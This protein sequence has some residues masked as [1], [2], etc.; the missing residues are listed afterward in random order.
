MRRV[1]PILPILLLAAPVSAE[2]LKELVDI[3][4]ARPNALIGMGLV[5]GLNG[6]GDDASS[7]A[8]RRQ[9]AGMMQKLG[10]NLDATALKQLK[11]KNI[12]QVSV[13]ASLPPFAHP[14]TGLDVVVSSVGTA[15]SLGGGTLI[16]TPLKGPDLVTYALA[17]GPVSLGGFSI[18]GQS[19]SKV[20]KN[21]PTVARIPNGARIE[22][23]PP[24]QIDN[25]GVVALS[26]HMPDFTTASRIAKAINETIGPATATVNDPGTVTLD[27]S[28]RKA[29]LVELMAQIEM[30]EV[31]PDIV[32]RVVIDERTGTVVVG[33]GV[34]L[35]AATIAH[36]GL[37][38][39]VQE[40]KQTSQPGPLTGKGATTVTVPQSNVEVEE[41]DGKLVYL[42]GAATAADV[43]NAMN[44][45][46]AKPR[47]LVAIFQALAQAGAIRAE[48][49]V[50]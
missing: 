41:A 5:V 43:A 42:S 28:G 18:E 7:P 37:T 49:V 34:R 13:T 1:L 12:A 47:D 9:L 11:A 48:I 20:T 15:S 33:N 22:K 32:A 30:I 39:K 36:G 23:A 17:Q 40:D 26:L 31:T 4:G 44:A 46:G 10:I 2:R 35:G 38:V 45:L 27:V 16:L 19:G 6:S 3:E 24:S 21:H 29:D 8:T 25:H 14:G 50:Q